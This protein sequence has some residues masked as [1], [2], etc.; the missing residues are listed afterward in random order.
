[1]EAGEEENLSDAATVRRMKEEE[2]VQCSASYGLPRHTVYDVLKLCAVLVGLAHLRH[3][4]RS[5][6]HAHGVELTEGKATHEDA[7]G[8]CIGDVG[9]PF[10]AD[11]GTDDDA[12]WPIGGRGWLQLRARHHDRC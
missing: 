12:L 8:P 9:D 4:P 5:G 6:G 11:R 10:L 1:M 7:E 2:L 3:L